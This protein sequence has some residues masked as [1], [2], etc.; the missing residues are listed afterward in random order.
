ARSDGVRSRPRARRE[1]ILKPPDEETLALPL[2]KQHIEPRE[3]IIHILRQRRLP[4]ADYPGVLERQG[5]QTLWSG[6]VE[7]RGH[8]RCSLPRRAKNRGEECLG[9]EECV[10]SN[11]AENH[12]AD[13]GDEDHHLTSAPKPRVARASASGGDGEAGT[14]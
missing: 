9:T 4:N 7:R 8:G 13:H 6:G 5:N 11:C 10:E 12:S 2:R 3:S 14:A 1:N